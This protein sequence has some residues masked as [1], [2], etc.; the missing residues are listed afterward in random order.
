M[1]KIKINNT[2]LFFDVYGSHLQILHDSVIE[3]PTL[4]VLH[5]G[6]GVADQ[7]LYVDFWSRF[8]DIAQVI[9]LDQR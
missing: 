1:P 4:L 9:F 8:S 7:P 6:H 2:H 5:G 3:K